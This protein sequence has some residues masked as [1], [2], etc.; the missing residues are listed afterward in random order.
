MQLDVEPV[1]PPP[2]FVRHTTPVASAGGV[3]AI[4]GTLCVWAAG[5]V[6]P[7]RSVDLSIVKF[8]AGAPA[9]SVGWRSRP[10]R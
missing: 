2:S 10:A 5:V 7:L 9:R 8:A 1:S 4:V 6:T 3:K